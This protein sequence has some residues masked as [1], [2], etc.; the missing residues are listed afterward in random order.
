[1]YTP[2]LL[3]FAGT[4]VT[5]TPM[6]FEFISSPATPNTPTSSPNAP[7]SLPLVVD[8][9][10][11]TTTALRVRFSSLILTVYDPSQTA[12]GLA[13]FE[14][15]STSTPTTPIASW[16]Q[17]PVPFSVP[18]PPSMHCHV[19]GT[20][21]IVLWQGLPKLLGTFPEG[22]L[23]S[24][25][26]SPSSVTYPSLTSLHTSVPSDLL[27]TL[28]VGG[29][30][31]CGITTDNN[32]LCWGNDS[33][34]QVSSSPS[35]SPHALF[36]PSSFSRTTFTHISSGSWHTLVCMDNEYVFAFGSNFRGQLGS[37]TPATGAP[38]PVTFPTTSSTVSQL[39]AIGHSSMVVFENGDV[40]VWGSNAAPVNP[41]IEKHLYRPSYESTTGFLGIGSSPLYAYWANPKKVSSSLVP[42]GGSISK[43]IP[44]YLSP[45]G[46][47]VMNILIATQDPGAPASGSPNSS[48]TP[49]APL[50]L[51]NP[52]DP[53]STPVSVGDEVVVT[54]GAYTFPGIEN[55]VE[56]RNVPRP[57]I[58]AMPRASPGTYIRIQ[59]S[60]ES[61]FVF[62]STDH[63]WTWG[64]VDGRMTK[65]DFSGSLAA[66][67]STPFLATASEGVAAR[68]LVAF[69]DDTC[70]SWRS[71]FSQL[72]FVSTSRVSVNPQSATISSWSGSATHYAGII[73]DSSILTC[74]GDGERVPIG[75]PMPYY[76]GH[77]G[78]TSCNFVNVA[79]TVHAV[80]A[81]NNVT[82]MTMCSGTTTVTCELFTWGATSLGQGELAAPIFLPTPIDAS[83]IPIYPVS[84]PSNF[85]SIAAG[86]DYVLV[87]VCPEND[88]DFVFGWGIFFTILLARSHLQVWSYKVVQT[89][90]TEAQ[91]T[92]YR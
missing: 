45:S 70:A 30:H 66:Y 60:S 19:E 84:D 81:G 47:S 59:S 8:I 42:S 23:L 21:C 64:Q 89:L 10:M 43:I 31:A 77:D 1:M 49:S 55:F 36:P 48:P 88:S 33:Y 17:A 80:V 92:N 78:T 54:W 65:Y 12:F 87:L 20:W 58:S 5:T 27:N 37:D 28:S 82:I 62:N 35:S 91:L 73:N 22:S 85:K 2:V 25:V 72:T 68:P 29:T 11:M 83:S 75:S 14:S 51:V 15:V 71:E 67:S 32:L 61:L 6:P 57:I 63:Y 53:Y 16:I 69:S 50:P 41:N 24:G 79:G 40:Y 26:L 7:T 46:D 38:S 4:A 76:L 86:I 52:N 44:P 13:S 56:T 74:T 90:N 18:I 3:D 34:G 9:Q 39:A